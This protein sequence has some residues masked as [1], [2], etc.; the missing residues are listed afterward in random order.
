MSNV[1]AETLPDVYRATVADRALTREEV[2]A[3]LKLSFLS[4]EIDLR[5]TPGERALLDTI[6]ATLWRL[7]GQEPEPPPIVSPLP[8]PED[9][10]GRRARIRTFA[11]ALPSSGARELA[12]SLAYLFVV[13]DH[14]LA[15]VEGEYLEELRSELSIDDARADALALAA[16][17]VITPGVH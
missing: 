13:G 14:A 5:A 17:K 6:N 12:Y 3:I 2:R 15:P 4:C 8:V 9:R 1:T 10:E 7:A 11:A 16:A